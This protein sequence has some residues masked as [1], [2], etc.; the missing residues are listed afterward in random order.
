MAAAA[1]MSNF[2]GVLIVIG[3]RSSDVSL[4]QLFSDRRD[5]T[6]RHSFG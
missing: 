5:E 1:D 4:Q 6:V 3:I 2:A